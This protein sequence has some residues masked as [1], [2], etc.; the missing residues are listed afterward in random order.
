M[1]RCNMLKEKSVSV[2]E[3]FI[4]RL[5]ELKANISGSIKRETSK[6]QAHSPGLHL[7]IWWDFWLID[8]LDLLGQPGKKKY[9]GQQM[10]QRCNEI[11]KESPENKKEQN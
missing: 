8:W 10:I 11:L 2:W 7:W 9:P 6:A 4:V 5:V 1:G 3:L